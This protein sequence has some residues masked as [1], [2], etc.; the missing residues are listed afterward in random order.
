MLEK[1]KALRIMLD[2]I[3]RIIRLLPGTREINLA[4]TSVQLAKMWAGRTLKDLGE[5]TPYPQSENPKNE[6]IEIEA[7]TVDVVNEYPQD[8]T[9]TAKIKQLR[10]ELGELEDTISKDTMDYKS[11]N[12]CIKSIAEARMWLGQELGRIRDQENIV[13]N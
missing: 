8:W 4:A 6:Q 5:Q 12:N 1:I 13:G 9:R 3:Y 7:D 10:K 2:M 11:L